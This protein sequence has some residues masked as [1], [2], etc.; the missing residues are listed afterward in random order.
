MD[1][2]LVLSFITDRQLLIMDSTTDHIYLIN[3]DDTS[4]TVESKA[5]AEI[6]YPVNACTITG[7]GSCSQL[8]LKMIKPNSLKFCQI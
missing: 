4:S 7:H 6:E 2:N 5:C 3:I 1:W 8:V